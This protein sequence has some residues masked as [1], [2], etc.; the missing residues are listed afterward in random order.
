MSTILE[1]S[2]AAT[3]LN[4]GVAVKV[5]LVVAG[6]MPMLGGASVA[7]AL[8][9]VREAFAGTPNAAMLTGMVLSTHALA[10]LL[11]STLAGYLGDRFG[12]KPMLTTGLIGF[13]VAGTS[14]FYLPDL[15]TILV[16]RFALGLSIALI[17]TSIT[18]L[19]GDLFD[20]E[21]R[22]KLLSRQ[23]AAATAGGV[24][25]MLFAGTLATLGWREAFLI[26]A[27]GALMLLPVLVFVPKLRPALAAKSAA[28]EGDAHEAK[29]GLWLVAPVTAMFLAQ[30]LF[31]I[32][33]TQIPGMLNSEFGA[34]PFQTS[35]AIAIMSLTMA[36]A[37]LAFSRIRRV[38]NSATIVALAFVF[39]IAGFAIVAIA[40][41]VVT[42]VLGLMCAA[43]GMGF[44]GPNINNWVVASAPTRLR[45]RATGVLTTGMFLGQFLSPVT[46]QPLIDVV[47]LR[48]TFGCIAGLSAAVV[49]GFYILGRRMDRGPRLTE[50]A[51]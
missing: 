13:A 22:Q 24:I 35:L 44:T 31:Y 28:G 47:G 6:F 50:R 12:R 2:A 32:I 45:G 21:T 34:N 4:P 8:P 23:F 11:F 43:T 40:P 25:F 49:V 1:R 51:V 14:G 48:P 19:I 30:V 36:P 15:P 10:I 46:T 38:G 33:P 42:V 17:M 9:A 37:A 39:P 7:P 3:A 27:V 20:D 26:Y 18:A 16:G 29:L 41:N 5:T